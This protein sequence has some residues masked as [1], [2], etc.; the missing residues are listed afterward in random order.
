MLGLKGTLEIL[1]YRWGTLRLIKLGDL[2]G[3]GS[4]LRSSG[5]FNE[6][7]FPKRFWLFTSPLEA[8]RVDYE[9]G[10]ELGVW[11]QPSALLS[12]GDLSQDMHVLPCSSSPQVFR[13]RLCRGGGLQLASCAS[14]WGW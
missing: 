8:K 7:I 13:V 5:F 10:E 1:V 9:F 6:G 12:R 3:K 2:P 4:L 11:V 14:D